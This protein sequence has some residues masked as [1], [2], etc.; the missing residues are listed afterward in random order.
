MTSLKNSLAVG[1][2]AFAAATA[3]F[4]FSAPAAA[5]TH[6]V[7]I[8]IDE[9]DKSRM[10]QA[11]GNAKNIEKYYQEMEEEVVIEIVTIG[12]GV[13]M[14]RSD[15]SPVSDLIANLSK[16]IK[17]I[18][19]S[20]CANTLHGMTEREGKAPPLLEQAKIVPSGAVRLMELQEQGYTY[21]R[22]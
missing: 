18:S 11:L 2:L 10:T 22:P 12:P 4:A 9:N 3:P 17:H 15:A 14:L 13:N 1:L 21:L 19:F 7:A 5:E 20:A 8:H 6:K 16:Q